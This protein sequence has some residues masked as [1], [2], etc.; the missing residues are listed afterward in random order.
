MLR[1]GGA[2]GLPATVPYV[3]FTAPIN[4]G[5]SGG[6]L[7]DRDGNVIGVVQAKVRQAEGVA[8]AIA[9]EEV[10][11]FLERTGIDAALPV[12][13]L[14]LG[15]AFD[16]ADKGIRM[17]V[18]AGFA[19]ASMSRTRIDSASSLGPLQLIVD[20]M[21]PPWDVARMERALLEESA[22]SNRT[23]TRQP[24]RV[25]GD[26]ARGRVRIGLATQ[27]GE[28]DD[29]RMVH[30]LVDTSEDVI[31][32][33]YVAPAA[34]IA[35]NLSVLRESLLSIEAVTL[36]PRPVI[37]SLSAR[38]VSPAEGLTASPIHLLPADTLNRWRAVCGLQRTG[39][40]GACTR[41]DGGV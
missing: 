12:V 23:A 9:I 18:P 8:F 28:N 31:V 22:F 34:D 25:R 36:A 13:R 21:A 39:G 7:A 27:S 17:R 26:P 20:R 10:K 11:R 29:E 19:D 15:P 32:A 24:D 4:P 3:Q 37:A 6:P 1:E 41:R 14:A 5:N 33:R 2:A 30:P 35:Y 16:F 40:A 38:M